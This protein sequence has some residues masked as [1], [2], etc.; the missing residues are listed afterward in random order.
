MGKHDKESLS[1]FFEHITQLGDDFSHWT[2]EVPKM[3]VI[4]PDI[5][6]KLARVEGFYQREEVKN[7]EVT[8]AS[9][10][11]RR[12]NLPFGIVTLYEDWEEKYLHYE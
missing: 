6:A 12:L 10:I 1:I 5:I 8:A 4:N 3:L 11:V 9:P 2:G 7:A